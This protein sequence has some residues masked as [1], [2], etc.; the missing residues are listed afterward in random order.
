MAWY[1]DVAPGHPVHGPYHDQEYGFHSANE[2]VLF[3]RLCLEVMQAG[4]SWEIVLKRRKGMN[5]AFD[6]FLVNKVA[7]YKAKDV[8]RLL[9]DPA[10]IRNR[11]KVKAIL[12]NAKRVQAIRK[13]HGSFA[14]WLDTHRPLP[15]AGWVKLFRKTFVFMGPE[16]V[17][18][19]LMSFGYLPG[20]HKPSCSIQK[21]IDRQK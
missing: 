20:A 10:I 6:R 3:E 12:E 19:F 15:K 2:R 8:A 18:E 1:C 7:A 11:L 4:L 21:I 9:K 14:K 16:I 13:A 17:G 5:K